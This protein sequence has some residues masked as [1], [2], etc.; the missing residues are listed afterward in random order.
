M[1]LLAIVMNF[2]HGV[3]LQCSCGCKYFKYRPDFNH[4]QEVPFFRFLSICYSSLYLFLKLL[5]P[6]G[7]L[8]IKYI[9]LLIFI[10]RFSQCT[11]REYTLHKIAGVW[12]DASHCQDDSNICP[13]SPIFLF[14]VLSIG[15]HIRA[16]FYQFCPRLVFSRVSIY[17][18]TERHFYSPD[19]VVLLHLM[20]H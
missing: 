3:F 13:V 4:S 11:L 8:T 16:H 12:A 5:W 15:Y 9:K 20:A 18:Q 19:K 6:H 7:L 17:C 1:W 2:Q 14:I 10:Y